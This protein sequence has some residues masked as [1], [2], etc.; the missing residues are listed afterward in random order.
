MEVILQSDPIDIDWELNVGWM[1]LLEVDQSF[2]KWF[3][4]THLEHN[5]KYLML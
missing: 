1:C 3:Q 2:E 4:S 5:T